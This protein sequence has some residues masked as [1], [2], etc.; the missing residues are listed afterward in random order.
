MEKRENPSTPS[1]E[2]TPSDHRLAA[3]TSSNPVADLN[4]N[5]PAKVERA[6][7]AID[8]AMVLKDMETPA[9]PRWAESLEDWVEVH[10]PRSIFEPWEAQQG[11][12]H[13]YYEYDGL[14]QRLGIRCLPTSTHDST[15][16]VFQAQGSQE[17]GKLSS[18]SQG[19]LIIGQSTRMY[20]L[21]GRATI[22]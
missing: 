15:S 12:E 10:M 18:Q 17:I 4:S 9:R 14:R 1:T 19:Q 16:R 5:D 3:S 21:S 2:A 7:N 22:G 11:D 6:L 20:I 13:T 8:P